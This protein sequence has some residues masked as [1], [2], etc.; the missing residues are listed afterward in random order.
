MFE[1]DGNSSLY[2][3][4]PNIAE[5]YTPIRPI[6]TPTFNSQYLFSPIFIASVPHSIF[7]LESFQLLQRTIVEHYL[8]HNDIYGF[9]RRNDQV[10]IDY[11]P[12]SIA[13]VMTSLVAEAN[14]KYQLV[15]DVHRHY[16]IQSPKKWNY[17]DFDRINNEDGQDMLWTDNK[18]VFEGVDIV[19]STYNRVREVVDTFLENPPYEIKDKNTLIYQLLS[20]P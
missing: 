19:M 17:I 6:L 12:H 9:L 16:K 20:V 8:P 11:L 15:C 10:G 5:V 3:I 4:D 2:S 1:K 7:L 18:T 14:K 13:S